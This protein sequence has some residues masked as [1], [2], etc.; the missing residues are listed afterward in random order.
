M[1]RANDMYSLALIDGCH[2]DEY[3]L[4]PGHGHVFQQF[5]HRMWD[6]LQGPKVN[7][8]VMPELSR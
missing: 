3:Y 4:L 2:C 8:L 7:P 5:V 1:F 6:E